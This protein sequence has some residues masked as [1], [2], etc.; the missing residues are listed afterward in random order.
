MLLHACNISYSP[1]LTNGI[2]DK[3]EVIGPVLSS[4]NM[5]G[6]ARVL[7][8]TLD[9]LSGVC[10]LPFSSW[11]KLV[12]SQFPVCMFAKC[13]P[14][15]ILTQHAVILH[16]THAEHALYAQCL[17]KEHASSLGD[18]ILVLCFPA[19]HLALQIL[20]VHGIGRLIC[21]V[22]IQKLY[23]IFTWN[24]TRANQWVW[25]RKWCQVIGLVQM[26]L[27]GLYTRQLYPLPCE[28]GRPQGSLCGLV[29]D[30]VPSGAGVRT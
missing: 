9:C 15:S 18:E 14:C 28:Y 2:V 6:G 22:A 19:L 11:T 3:Q 23:C 27:L 24:R 16:M 30:V 20:R 13:S 17:L 7:T 21:A 10:S 1:H 4:H 8:L 26:A 12:P 29:H 5:L 25:L